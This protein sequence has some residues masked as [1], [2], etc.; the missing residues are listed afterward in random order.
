MSTPMIDGMPCEYIGDGVY[1][2]KDDCGSIILRANDARMPSD[3][4]VLEPQV[5]NA[6]VRVAHSWGLKV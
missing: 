6:L 1:V 5:L 2:L 3:T 4:I